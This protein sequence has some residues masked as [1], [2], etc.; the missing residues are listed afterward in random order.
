MQYATQCL[1]VVNNVLNLHN[2]LLYMDRKL[3]YFIEYL[4]LPLFSDIANN[5]YMYVARSDV[6][7]PAAPMQSEG[8]PVR[9]DHTSRGF[10]CGGSGRGQG[11][12]RTD[13]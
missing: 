6:N 1:S 7:S 12:T 13:P 4:Q 2:L 10:L 11:S 3:E 8:M 9:A 5:M